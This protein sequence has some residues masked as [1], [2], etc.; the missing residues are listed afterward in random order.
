MSVCHKK[1]KRDS[2]RRE[3]PF[4]RDKAFTYKE[5]K[6]FCIKMYVSNF[7]H[8]KTHIHYFRHQSVEG[9]FKGVGTDDMTTREV[10]TMN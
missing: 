7:G 8:A 6:P 2:M 9:G 3:A 5:R 1:C 10:G 4:I